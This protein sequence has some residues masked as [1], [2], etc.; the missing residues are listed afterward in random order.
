MEQG[1]NSAAN[2]RKVQIEKGIDL[3]FTKVFVPYFKSFVIKARPK[4]ILE[5]GSGTG[6]MAKEI[7]S[8][9]EY[10]E[11]IE[12][13]EE[14]VNVS[15][16]ILSQTKVQILNCSI[17]EYYSE[18]RFDFIFSHLCAHVIDDFDSF[19][20]KIYNYLD[21][22]GIWKFSIPHPCFYNE[23]KQVFD[24]DFNYMKLQKIEYDLTI[25]KSDEV[26]KKVPYI[27]RPLEWYIERIVESGLV[28]KSFEEIY[29][30]EDIQKLYSEHWDKPRYL[31]FSG[32]T[33]R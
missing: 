29:P 7:Q 28:M 22:Y 15:N 27:H 13:A 33:N 19:L 18:R 8:Y 2:V 12:P 9:C 1:W 30:N 16:L 3:T 5:I 17:D 6:H 11:G 23:Y 32:I 21:E 4:Y 24:S 26:I 10:Y 31:V 25:T 20:D 14:M